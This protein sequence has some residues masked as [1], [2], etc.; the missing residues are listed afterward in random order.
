MGT[1]P[2]EFLQRAYDLDLTHLQWQSEVV[3][4]L[5]ALFPKAQARFGFV[6]ELENGDCASSRAS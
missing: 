6:Y 2:F 5:S 1:K 4:G 3:D